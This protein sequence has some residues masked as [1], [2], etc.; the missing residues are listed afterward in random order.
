MC[1]CGSSFSSDQLTL[2]FV[3][4]A[5]LFVFAG[6]AIGPCLYGWVCEKLDYRWMFWVQAIVGFV[7]FS[8]N[9]VYLRETRGGVLLSRRAQ[10]LT[11]ATGRLHAAPGDSERADLKTLIRVSVSR[12]IGESPRGNPASRL[13]NSDAS[14]FSFLSLSLPRHRTHRFLRQLV[15]WCLLGVHLRK[16]IR[17]NSLG[18][19]S[20][21]RADSDVLSRLPSLPLVSSS[22]T[23]FPSFSEAP[24]ALE[25]A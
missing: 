9:F 18:F 25:L 1:A 4:F 10:Q 21:S 11:K 14:S 8:G 6:Q 5:R 3:P 2:P 7:S 24:M 22:S 20:R 19:S 13:K 15:G 17:F 12:P 16:L 23:R